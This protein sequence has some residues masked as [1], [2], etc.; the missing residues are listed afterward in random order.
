MSKVEKAIREIAFALMVAAV[1]AAVVK[2][3][4]SRAAVPLFYVGVPIACVLFLATR[5]IRIYK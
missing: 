1:T 5:N 2:I 3:T 4:L